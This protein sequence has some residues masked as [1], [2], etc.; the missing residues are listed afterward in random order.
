MKL[1]HWVFLAFTLIGI[2]FVTHF[3][4]AKNHGGGSFMN[5][6][7]LSGMRAG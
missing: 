4:L 2:L 7:G 6:I 1:K 3:L 5:G